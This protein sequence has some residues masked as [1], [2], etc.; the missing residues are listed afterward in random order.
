MWPD[1][2]GRCRSDKCKTVLSLETSF[3]T[4]SGNLTWPCKITISKGQFDSKLFDVVCK[5]TFLH[6][7]FID[8]LILPDRRVST[9]AAHRP[10]DT[11]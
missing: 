3:L 5:Q 8:M 6:P 1:F 11:A 10:P 4:P 2:L 7:F 9:V